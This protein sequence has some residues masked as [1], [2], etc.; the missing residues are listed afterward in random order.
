MRPGVRYMS[1]FNMCLLMIPIGML[2]I[3]IPGCQA[4]NIDRPVPPVNHSPYITNLLVQRQVSAS[5]EIPASCVAA[6]PDSDNL[7]YV[8]SVS[9]GIIKGKGN[10]VSWLAPEYPGNYLIAVIVADGRGGTCSQSENITVME[11]TQ[12]I[13]SLKIKG[14]KVTAPNRNPIV[15]D[16]SPTKEAG[17]ENTEIKAGTWETIQIECIAEDKDGHEINYIWSATAGKIH[18]QG[19][20]VNWT[21]PG[22]AGNYSITTK[23]DCNKGESETYVFDSIIKCLSCGAK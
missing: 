14:I 10:T 8:W 1:D 12:K 20:K 16:I 21:L 23:V 17:N 15:I 11:N 3:L 4:I 2:L 18:G 6:D 5:T 9:G 22:V 19:S 7:T 13:A